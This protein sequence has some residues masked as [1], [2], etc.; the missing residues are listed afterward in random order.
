[1]LQKDID[2]FPEMEGIIKSQVP[3]GRRATPDEIADFVVF[4]SSPK[5]SY[6]TGG[7]LLIDGGM[8]MA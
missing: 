6:M 2:N 3:M 4:L 1:M 7:S 8:V 5:A